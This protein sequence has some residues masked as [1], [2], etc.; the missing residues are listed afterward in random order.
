MRRHVKSVLVA[1]A[2]SSTLL[3]G[4][5]C[6]GQQDQTEIKRRV[7]NKVAPLYPELARRMNVSGS[8]KLEVVIAPNGSVKSEKIVG[9]HPVLAQS[10]EDAVRKWKWA[11]SPQETTDLIEIKFSPKD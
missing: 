11:P 9:G 2:I 3:C 1:C 10:A 8:V 7:V 5:W 6:F 4:S